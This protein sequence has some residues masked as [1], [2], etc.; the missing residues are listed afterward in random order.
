M[1]EHQKTEN[2]QQKKTPAV[3]K[4]DTV[5]VGTVL[6]TDKINVNVILRGKL[7][8]YLKISIFN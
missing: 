7:W 1:V 3:G 5:Y 4:T 8:L 6:K 2:A